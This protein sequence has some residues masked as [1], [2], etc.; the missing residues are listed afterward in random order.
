MDPQ[1]QL[2]NEGEASSDIAIGIGFNRDENVGSELFSPIQRFLIVAALGLAVA[3]SRK[4]RLINQ[5]KK[6]VELRVRNLIIG[7]LY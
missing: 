6:S 7:L 2:V 3:G 4:N 5:L 1:E